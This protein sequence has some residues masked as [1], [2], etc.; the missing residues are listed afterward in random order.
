M[1]TS[2]QNGDFRKRKKKHLWKSGSDHVSDQFFPIRFHLNYFLGNK[3]ANLKVH[4]S[5]DTR[6]P[7][8]PS[9]LTIKY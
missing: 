7:P 3:L 9:R 4:A 8:F 6:L 1:A 5:A 2:L